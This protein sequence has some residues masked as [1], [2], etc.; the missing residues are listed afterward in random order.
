[1]RNTLNEKK[2][3]SKALQAIES[4]HSEIVRTIEEAIQ[5]NEWVVV[6]MKQNVVVK[7]ARRYLDEKQIPYH[8]IEYG[9]YFSGWKIRLAIK[10]WSGWPTFPQIFHQGKLIGGFKDLKMYKPS[11]D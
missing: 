3:D 8:Y 9:S 7:S 6:G 2:I 5:K 11:K 1:M 4:F 10:L